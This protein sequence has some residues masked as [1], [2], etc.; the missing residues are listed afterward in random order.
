MKHRVLWFCTSALA[1]AACSSDGA[2][3]TGGL[4]PVAPTAGTRSLVAGNQALATPPTAAGGARAVPPTSSGLPVAGTAPVGALA[5]SGALTPP[6]TPTGGSAAPT[7]AGASALPPTAGS[8]ATQP[9]TGGSTAAAGGAAA[10]GAAGVNVTQDPTVPDATGDCPDFKSGVATIS[11]LGGISLTVGAKKEGTGSLI[12]YWH[13]TGSS[14]SEFQTMIPAAA[15]KE[16]S[17][18]G[19][20]IVAFSGST[21][22]GG[23]C[24]GTSTFGKDDF[25]I[26]DLIAGCAVK[27]YGINPRQIYTTGCSAGGLMAGCM[28]IAR[29]NYIAATAPNSGGITVGYGA[30]QDP[31]HLPAVMTM[32]GDSADMVIVT[33]SE[34]S[35]AYDN[36]MMKAGAFAIDCDHGGGHCGAP[37]D[38][39]ASAW[40]FMKDHPYGTKPSPYLAAGLPS[41][42]P[43]YCKI[44]V[45]TSRMP[46]GG[47]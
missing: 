44:W 21:G 8:G 23:D 18:Q 14:S 15:Q 41:T 6:L 33:F 39:Q 26:A 11:G 12:F 1:L 13:G 36:Y 47:M 2:A 34:T 25:K 5:G 17:D 4:S 10:P 30:I 40:Q 31:T 16:I 28:G 46:L 43:K 7:T 22:T 42:F 3:G 38:L 20:I 9:A 27:N 19:G 35:E 24:S 29:S 37:A 45:P 32:H